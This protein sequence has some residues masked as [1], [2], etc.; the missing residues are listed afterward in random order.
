MPRT[1]PALLLLLLAAAGCRTEPEPTPAQAAARRE[2][3]R[4]ACVAEALQ[5]RA[6][7]RLAA[8]DTLL[9]EARAQGSVPAV[10]SAPHTF[11]EV[12]AT[13][14]DLRAHE[15]AYRDSALSARSP[16]DSL[17]FEQAAASFRVRR[18]SP[19]TLE[20]NVQRDYLRDF[21]ASRENP[22]HVCNHLV[23]DGDRPRR[24]GG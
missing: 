5:E 22:E 11:A 1:A 24:R 15:T 3:R 23:G 20:A 7:T 8:L 6:R 21:V 2:A 16:E 13:L 12:Y 4:D 18:P 19:E 9:E 10:V 17:R 14:A